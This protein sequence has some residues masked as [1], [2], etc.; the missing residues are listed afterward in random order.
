MARLRFPG[1]CSRSGLGGGRG[2]RGRIGQ[3]NGPGSARGNYI[4]RWFIYTIAGLGDLDGHRSLCNYF[5]LDAY[6]L[7]GCLGIAHISERSPQGGSIPN[8]ILISQP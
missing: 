8:V 6:D 2:G 1:S 7:I 3:L 4:F 5:E